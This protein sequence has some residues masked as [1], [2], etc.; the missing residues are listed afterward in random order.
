LIILGTYEIQGIPQ[1]NDIASELTTLYKNEYIVLACR[2]HDVETCG[3]LEVPSTINLCTS[4]A[5]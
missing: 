5:E 3:Y 1:Y 4:C 2:W